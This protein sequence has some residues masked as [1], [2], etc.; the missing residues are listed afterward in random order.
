MPRNTIGIKGYVFEI[1]AWWRFH[2]TR[3]MLVDGW[4]WGWRQKGEKT[5]EGNT[6]MIIRILSIFQQFSS[7]HRDHKR[8]LSDQFTRLERVWWR[9]CLQVGALHNLNNKFLLNAI[10]IMFKRKC[11]TFSPAS[12]SAVKVCQNP[13]RNISWSSDEC[14]KSW[15]NKPER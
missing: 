3:G 7:I 4:F 11:S 1:S 5:A 9:K 15:W 2:S 12:T 6:F 14:S 13:T 8:K 10:E